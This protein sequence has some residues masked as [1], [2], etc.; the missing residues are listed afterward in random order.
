MG[1]TAGIGLFF[2]LF[3]RMLEYDILNDG[4]DCMKIGIFDSGIGGLTVL[5]QIIKK[6]PNANYLYYGDTLHLPYGEKTKEQLLEYACKIIDFFLEQ[7]VN[8]IV[9]ACG[10]VSST[11]YENLK[12]I[13]SIEMISVVDATVT[14]INKTNID[15]V[16]VLATSKTIDS[17]MFSKK[18]SNINVLEVSCP[19]FVPYLE[20]QIGDKQEILSEYL[21]FIKKEK[22][23]HIILGCTH[24][25]LLEAD[26][27]NYFNYEIICYNM[28]LFVANTIEIEESSY[29]LTL[30]FSKVD[31][32]LKE[33]IKKIL[34]TN[35]NI[36]EV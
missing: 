14:A 11:I 34:D 3:A 31:E 2:C 22:I 15:K 25:P 35:Y 28:G 23:E 5:K 9:I 17:H 36:I 21:E 12:T 33:N 13:Y 29:H 30:Y 10:T 16:A 18:L 32:S 26:I 19:K 24:Y 8:K 1:T 4:D 7:G 27:K 20:H 6:Y